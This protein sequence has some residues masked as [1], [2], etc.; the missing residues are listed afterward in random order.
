MIYVDNAIHPWRGRLWCHMF[1]TGNRE[2][3]HK[4]AA[5]IGLRRCWFQPDKR[6]PH[7]DLTDTKRFAAIRK[8]AITVD[9]FF[10]VKCIR[11]NRAR[12]NAKVKN[13]KA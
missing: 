12:Q 9:R 13:R 11:A 6:L 4:F 1:T 8:G 2:E 3:L 10:V 5:S 7:Y